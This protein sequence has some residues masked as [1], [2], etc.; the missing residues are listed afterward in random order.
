[1]KMFPAVAKTYEVP[2]DHTACAWSRKRQFCTLKGISCLINQK[3]LPVVVLA[4]HSYS[5]LSMLVA[6]FYSIQRNLVIM[7]VKV[8]IIYI[9]RDS[10]PVTVGIE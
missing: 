3:S 1:M 4:C 7:H 6:M 5:L 9:T 10:I 8:R 2:H